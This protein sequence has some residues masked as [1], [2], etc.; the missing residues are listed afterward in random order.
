MEAK[1]TKEYAEKLANTRMVNENNFI[2]NC[3]INEAIELINK[4]KHD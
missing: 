4:Q 3:D 1:H 2:D